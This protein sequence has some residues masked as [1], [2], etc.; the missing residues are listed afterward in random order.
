[1]RHIVS[2]H[3]SVSYHVLIQQEQVGVVVGYI[4]LHVL[5]FYDVFQLAALERVTCS[6]SENQQR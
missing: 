1:M 4:L 2:Y 6:Q 3:V 5:A